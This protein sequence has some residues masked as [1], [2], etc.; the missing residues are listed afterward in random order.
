MNSNGHRHDDHER[1]SPE[2]ADWIY[3]D[4]E[5]LRPVS[6]EPECNLAGKMDALDRDN[7]E[8]Y[9]LMRELLQSYCNGEIDLATFEQ[10]H[11]DLWQTSIE[12]TNETARTFEECMAAKWER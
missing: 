8:C 2:F 6:D 1:P 12:I 7:F 5:P 9:Q 3:G 4:L 11:A 10:R